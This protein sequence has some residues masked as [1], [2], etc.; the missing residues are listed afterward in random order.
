MKDLEERIISPLQRLS[1]AV[2]QESARRVDD[3]E[4]LRQEVRALCDT[5]LADHAK[6]S[7]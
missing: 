7:Q 5:Q 4:K 1:E 6:T 3:L 2:S